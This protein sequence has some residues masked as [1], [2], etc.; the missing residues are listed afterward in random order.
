M[1]HHISASSA[2]VTSH[3][4]P[5]QYTLLIDFVINIHF[6]SFLKSPLNCKDPIFKFLGSKHLSEAHF[7]DRKFESYRKVG[8]VFFLVVRFS[9]GVGWLAKSFVGVTYKNFHT[10]KTLNKV[11]VDAASERMHDESQGSF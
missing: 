1:L 8:C 5:K 6:G 10:N 2:S 9:R 7:S 4:K 3:S 11:C